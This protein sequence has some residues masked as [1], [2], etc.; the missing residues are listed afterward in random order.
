[1]QWKEGPGGAATTLAASG[2]LVEA[3]ELKLQ[4]IAAPST[5]PVFV[6]AR[7]DT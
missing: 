1:M 2:L 3:N 6:Q 7:P 5:L 4:P